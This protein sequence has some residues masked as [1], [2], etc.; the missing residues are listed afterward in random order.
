MK[1]L[2]LILSAA[3]FLAA[4]HTA[5]GAQSWNVTGEEI[6]RFDA[7]VVDVLCE[8][9][10]DCPPNCGDGRRQLGLLTDDGKLILPVKNAAPFAGAA[11]ELIAFCGQKVTAD[12]LFTENKGVRV[13]A[14][15]FV[16]PVDGKWQRAN[17]F[18]VK[19]AEENGVDP[20]SKAKNNWFR[21]DP[22]VKAIIEADGFLGLGEEADKQYLADN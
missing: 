8:L 9:N 14:L 3:G 22:R 17:R 15:Q 13:F 7:K 10:G 20:N 18:L 4:A 1:K 19:W 2:S 16:K 5:Q 11:D 12:G 6:A 21:K